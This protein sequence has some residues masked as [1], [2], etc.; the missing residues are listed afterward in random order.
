LRER[1]EARREVADINW[2]LDRIRAKEAGR[3]A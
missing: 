1:I 2:L 3:G